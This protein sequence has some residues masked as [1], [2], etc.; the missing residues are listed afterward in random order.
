VMHHDC[1]INNILFDK[2]TNEV[3][4]PVDLD[5]TMPGKFFSDIGDM[6]RT[7]ACTVDENSIEWELIE[8][9]P[10]FYEAILKGYLEGA[11]NIFTDEEKKNIH[12]S[13]LILTYMQSLR[14]AADHLNGDIY[15]RI[16]YKEQNLS[17]ALNQLILL[18]KL[19]EY[20]LAT[21]S[22]NPYR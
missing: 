21:Y 17:R 15:Y 4:C 6:I 7:M 2:N 9:R 11:G 5:T 22:F 20:L 14:F 8:V 1:K 3:I 16:S 18:E 12:F 19:E 10:A 13:G